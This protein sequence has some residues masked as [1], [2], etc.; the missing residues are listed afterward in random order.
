[1]I[2]AQKYEKTNKKKTKKQ[3]TSHKPFIITEDNDFVR[4]FVYF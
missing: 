2:V 3:K 1:M 4:L